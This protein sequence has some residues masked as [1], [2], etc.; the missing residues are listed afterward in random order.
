[1]AEL[2]R[3]FDAPVIE[4]YAM[5][6]AAHQMCSNPL[7]PA[8]RKPGHVGP[9]AGPEVAI[10]DDGGTALPAGSEGE[11]VIRGAN[12]AAGYLNNPQANASAFHRDGNGHRDGS[13]DWFRTGDQGTMDAE[14]YVKVTGRLK[15]IIN[16]GG[17]KV[18][19]L[20]VDDALMQHPA[21]RQVCTF[22]TPHAKLGEDVAA[23]VVLA[24]NATTTERDL[25]RFV[26]RA[27]GRLQD[28]APNRLRGRDSQGADR[29]D[30]AHRPRPGIGSRLKICVFGAG[31]VGGYLAALLSQAGADVSIVARGAHLEA[32]QRHGLALLVGGDELRVELPATAQPA[33]LGKQDVVL[34]TLKAHSIPSAV[35]GIRALLH[36]DTA[37]VSA[38]NGIP[39]WYFHGLDSPFGERHVESVDPG[40]AIWQGIGPQR[41]IGCVVYP[42]AEVVRPGVVR[43]L[44]DNRLILGEPHGDRSERVVAL[45][46]L[47]LAAG[48]KAPIRPRLRNDVWM[49]LWGNLAFNPL[50]ALTGATLDV[51]ATDPGTRQVRA[52]D[53]GG[54]GRRWAKPSARVLQWTWRSAS[55]APRPWAPT[56]RPCCR[57]WNWAGRLNSTRWC[58]PCASSAN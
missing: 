47:F 18:A 51:L 34:V 41:A 52:P 28:A 42:S 21:V 55:T 58:A 20:E 44:S 4:A 26:G 9:A 49:K 10:M 43:H 24:E 7:P 35:D 19:P 25:R 53:D 46:S 15:E 48:L 50:S 3:V 5:T 38:V 17:E 16:R 6:E 23:A 12:V 54:K 57:T 36:Q 29:Q 56:A 32:I 40:G 31:A 33:Q 2:E 30:P 37:V 1:M 13:G 27:A 8:V 45:A 14:G 39:W 11:I 22:A